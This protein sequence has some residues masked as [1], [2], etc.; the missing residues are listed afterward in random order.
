MK[1]FADNEVEEFRRV[2]LDPAFRSV[3][4]VKPEASRS[5][6]SETYFVCRGFM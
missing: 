3:N 5:E 6:S 4:A 1:Y 2:V